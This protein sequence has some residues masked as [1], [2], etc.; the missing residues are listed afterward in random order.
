VSE[1]E[2]PGGMSDDEQPE[3]VN[4]SLWANVEAIETEGQ[5]LPQPLLPQHWVAVVPGI[6]LYDS[7][8][9]VPYFLIHQTFQ[10]MVDRLHWPNHTLFNPYGGLEDSAG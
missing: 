9:S 5:D 2:S 6:V 3:L 7:L 8:V 4:S 1:D 10:F